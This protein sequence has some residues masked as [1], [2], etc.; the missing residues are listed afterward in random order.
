MGFMVGLAK[1][2]SFILVSEP[3][4]LEFESRP[5]INPA[6]RISHLQ[7]SIRWGLNST[8]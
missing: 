6:V 3:G 8:N 1:E 2:V 5:R 7:K 4:G